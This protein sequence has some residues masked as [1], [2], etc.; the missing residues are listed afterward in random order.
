MKNRIWLALLLLLGCLLGGCAVPTVDQLY[1]VPKRPQSYSEL[2]AVFDAA[3]TDLEYTA[4][5]SGEN[6]QTIQTADLDGDGIQEYLVFARSDGD[7]SLR[8]L[9]FAHTD[10]SYQLTDT[11]ACSGAS[12]DLV[13]Y[14]QMD[15]EGGVELLVGTRISEQIYRSVSVYSY[16]DRTAQLVMSTSYVRYLTGDLDGDGLGEL[17]VLKPGITDEEP[18]AAALFRIENGVG[19]RSNEV[20]LSCPVKQIGSILTGTLADGIAGVY[21]S[22][23]DQ[24]AGVLTDVLTWSGGELKNTALDSAT[25][26]RVENLGDYSIYPQDIDKD[27]VVEMPQ[28]IRA[29][30]PNGTWNQRLIRWY[31]LDSKGGETDKMVTYHDFAGGWYLTLAEEWI[32]NLRLS[33]DGGSVSFYQ[34]NPEAGTTEKIFSVHILTGQNREENAVIENRFVLHKGEQVIYAARLEVASGALSITQEDLISSFRLVNQA[35]K[36]GEK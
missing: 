12:F 16:S 6:L 35:F 22:G 3:M 36:N 2:Q 32:P 15:G 28:V 11:L 20:A 18:G 5:R 9:I 14:S 17:L 23:T 27:G 1:C 30:D 31:A 26:T 34:G 29:R 7:K 21:I 33:A 8:I 19:K 13:Q 25:G 10:G 4:P 24:A